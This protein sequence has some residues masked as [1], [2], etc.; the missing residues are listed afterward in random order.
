MMNDT[1]TVQKDRNFPGKWD[2]EISFSM[3]CEKEEFM[4]LTK[5]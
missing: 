2:E 3:D 1:E 4:N 5:K